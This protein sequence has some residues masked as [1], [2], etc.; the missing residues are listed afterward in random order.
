MCID[1]E[2]KPSSAISDPAR[3]ALLSRQLVR[4][5]MTTRRYRS[6]FSMCAALLACASALDAQPRAPESSFNRSRARESMSSTLDD[7]QL[8]PRQP[9]SASSR[10]RV[11]V[12]AVSGAGVGLLASLLMP[13][14]SCSPVEGPSCQSAT[15]TRARLAVGWTVGGAAV[16]ALV[17][18]L[19]ARRSA[20]HDASPDLRDADREHVSTAMP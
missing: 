4:C 14:G 11:V 12:G 6:L 7:A 16:G 17:G 8:A 1:S 10:R 18:A 19:T 2:S 3:L 20:R 15:S 9:T 13:V 5:V